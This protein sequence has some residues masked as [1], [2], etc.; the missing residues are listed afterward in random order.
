MRGLKLVGNHR[1]VPL[2]Y[3]CRAIRP[4]YEG[5][6]TRQDGS[7]FNRFILAVARSAPPMRG[8]KLSDAVDWNTEYLTAR[9]AIRPAYE[10]IETK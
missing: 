8:L 1:Y 4:A 6:E 2:S 5:I 10:G 7:F 9:R 3:R